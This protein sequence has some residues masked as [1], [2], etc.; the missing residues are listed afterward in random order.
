MS[1]RT[2]KAAAAQIAPV[3]D[4]P[5]GTLEKVLATAAE[6]ARNGAGVVVFPETFIPYYPY[7]SFIEPP[8]AIGK[9]HLAL[10]EQAVEV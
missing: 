1:A 10:Y 5:G 7:F 2:V 8:V 3:L 9:K 4:R 6:A